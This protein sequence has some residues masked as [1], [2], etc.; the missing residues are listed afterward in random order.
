MKTWIGNL[1]MDKC[2]EWLDSDN[3]SHLMRVDNKGEWVNHKGI[4]LDEV[5]KNELI[6]KTNGGS[7]I[8]ICTKNLRI[9]EVVE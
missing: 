9:Y 6:I 4:F 8:P 7:E 1:F 3:R 2:Y 5:L